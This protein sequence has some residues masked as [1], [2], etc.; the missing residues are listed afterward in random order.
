[1]RDAVALEKDLRP[2][3]DQFF[4]LESKFRPDARRPNSPTLREAR[5]LV[6]ELLAVLRPVA[7]ATQAVAACP[8]RTDAE[9]MIRRATSEAFDTL[10]LQ[11]NAA[12]ERC[13]AREASLAC[14][15][16]LSPWIVELWID[17]RRRHIK[18][19]RTNMA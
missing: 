18:A 19:N 12:F 2:V 17:E 4:V 13:K 7:N 9:E 16:D 10:V 8:R 1:M 6:S 5:R 11:Y 14:L 15:N 3:R